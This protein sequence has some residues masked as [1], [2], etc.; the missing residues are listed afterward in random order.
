MMEGSACRITDDYVSAVYQM[1]WE[2]VEL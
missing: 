1:V 2:A